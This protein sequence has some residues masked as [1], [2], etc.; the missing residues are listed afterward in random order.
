MTTPA[1]LLLLTTTYSISM[2]ANFLWS[3]TH[4]SVSNILPDQYSAGSMQGWCRV[5]VGLKQGWCRAKRGSQPVS[6]AI[7]GT[8]QC[9]VALQKRKIP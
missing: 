3:N 5:N 1:H 2:S 9:R 4:V 8:S 7:P 6:H